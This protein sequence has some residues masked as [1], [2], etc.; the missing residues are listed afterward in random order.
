M[1][2][3]WVVELV[4]IAPLARP[5]CQESSELSCSDWLLFCSPAV[6]LSVLSKSTH[7]LSSVRPR[8]AECLQRFALQTGFRLSFFLQDVSL[9]GS[10]N[11]D[12]AAR[13]WGSLTAGS[14]RGW[15]FS[16]GSNIL[17]VSLNRNHSESVMIL[18]Y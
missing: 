17:S 7:R 5:V 9:R 13:C 16:T 15:I 10:R 4:K 2:P 14:M 1:P 8:A 3:L 18:F 6:V 12:P 11:T